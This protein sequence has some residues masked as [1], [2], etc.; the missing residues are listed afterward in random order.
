MR[1]LSTQ[2]EVSVL[3]FG[4]HVVSGVEG[5]GKEPWAL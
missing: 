4:S 5:R 3:A 1:G 2:L